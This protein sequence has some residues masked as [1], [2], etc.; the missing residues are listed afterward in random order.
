MRLL[1]TKVFR[2]FWLWGTLHNLIILLS[3][4]MDGLA[5]IIMFFICFVKC[6]L[7]CS[8]IVQSSLGHRSLRK[9]IQNI[10]QKYLPLTL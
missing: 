4:S 2:G 5:I 9:S 7:C 1:T 3:M 8:N 10:D 6:G